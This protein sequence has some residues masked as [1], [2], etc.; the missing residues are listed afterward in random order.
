MCFAN[1]YDCVVTCVNSELN[2]TALATDGLSRGCE[3]VCLPGI[4]LIDSVTPTVLSFEM[5]MSTYT[6]IIG[7]GIAI[8]IVCILWLCVEVSD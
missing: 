7:V 8:C 6:T 5:S 4:P 2:V 1:E 3:I